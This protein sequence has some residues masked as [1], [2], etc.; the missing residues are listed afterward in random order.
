MNRKERRLLQ[1]K[2]AQPYAPA[3]T[4]AGMDQE[5]LVASLMR[6]NA[7]FRAGDLLLADRLCD[8]V[9][10]LSPGHADALNLKA[11]L[12]LDRGDAAGAVR[13]FTK[14]VS[15]VPGFAQA[16]FNLGTALNA[17]N[18]PKRAIRAFVQALEIDP[19]YSEAHYNL[20]ERI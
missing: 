14:V 17:Q 5:A 11:A 16:H 13:L 9:L 15:L 18:K 4:I 6:A 12:L 20:V 3:G 7:A 19:G 10:G 2:G 1:K 8:E